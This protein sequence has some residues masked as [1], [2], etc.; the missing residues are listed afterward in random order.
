MSDTENILTVTNL[1]KRFPL[2]GT[3]RFVH[4]VNGVS[5]VLHRGETLSIVGESGCGKST[6]ARLCIRL[7]NP[8]EGSVYFENRNL[9]ALS[10]KEL[11]MWRRKMQL[12]FQDPYASLNPRRSVGQT[13][14][15]PFNIHKVGSRNTRY[16]R[17]LSLLELVGLNRDVVDRYPH[18]FSGGQRQRIGI[19]RAIALQPDLL[20]LDEPVSALDVSIQSQIL[21]LLVKLR[22]KMRLS[23]LFISHDLAVVK[24]IS[25]RVAVMY[26][27]QIVEIADVDQI[28]TNPLHPYTLAL[29]DS[30][31]R[32][33]ANTKHK[34]TP[35]GGDV[36][37]PSSP[38]TGCPFHTRCPRA[39]KICAQ[40]LP[41]EKS[42]G[43][44]SG[45]YVRC[46]LY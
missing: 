28:Y 36:P 18:E 12:V 9:M 5:F 20:V 15:E 22:E 24:H 8:S 35:L 1:E 38:P 21:N 6:L 43:N 42:A 10:P 11:R 14:M 26:L 33:Q 40:H 2:K 3:N 13:I 25:D 23:F 39:M 4:A 16:E 27:G 44:A 32:V 37:D 29:L 19:A 17:M 41:K 34:R 30:I 31:P 46:H 45:H 7:I